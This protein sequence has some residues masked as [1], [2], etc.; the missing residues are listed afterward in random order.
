MPGML[1]ES[2]QELIT[3]A[4]KLAKQT[5]DVTVGASVSWAI[6]SKIQPKDIE[7][8][9]KKTNLESQI[10]NTRKQEYLDTCKSHLVYIFNF[11]ATC[12]GTFEV[13]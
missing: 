13:T 5:A 12:K 10:S 2:I 3:I 8:N 9:A 11:L 1:I 7:K 6:Q 4:T